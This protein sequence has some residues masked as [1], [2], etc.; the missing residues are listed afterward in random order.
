[1]TLVIKRRKLPQIKG[2][3]NGGILS[4]RDLPGLGKGSQILI[5]LF[6]FSLR[7]SHIKL[8]DLAAR[9]IPR[10]CHLGMNRHLCAMHTERRLSKAK[11]RIGNTKAEWKERLFPDRVK[12]AVSYIN[13]FCIMRVFFISDLDVRAVI[14][15]RG[16]CRRQLAGGIGLSQQH[17]CK[18]APHLGA[19]LRENEDIPNRHHRAEIYRSAGVDNQH[20]MLIHTVQRQDIPDLALCQQHVTRNG[21]AV[22]SFARD[23]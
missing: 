12:I 14:L 20:K 9:V 18:R 21:S 17:I 22:I 7:S 8:H 23:T 4:S 16:P 11:V 6:Q 10:V 2:K 3:G 5:R 13:A 1:M 19:E 15:P